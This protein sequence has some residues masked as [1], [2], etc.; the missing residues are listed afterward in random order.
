MA[1]GDLVGDGSVEVVVQTKGGRLYI[2]DCAG[3]AEGKAPWPLYM[4]NNLRNGISDGSGF[5]RGRAKHLP[6]SAQAT[7]LKRA[8]AAGDWSTALTMYRDA[9]QTVQAHADEVGNPKALQLRQAGMLSIARILNTRAQRYDE[10]AE[11]YRTAVE[12]APDTWLACQAIAECN[13]MAQLH[14]SEVASLRPTLAK[15]VAAYLPALDRLQLP[16]SDLCRFAAAQ[17]CLQ[18]ERPEGLAIMRKLGEHATPYLAEMAKTNA[19]YEG[20]PFLLTIWE[21]PRFDLMAGVKTKDILPGVSKGRYVKSLSLG[22]NS[23]AAKDFSI[24]IHCTADVKRA[25]ALGKDWQRG[26]DGRLHRNIE[27][28]LGSSD[29]GSLRMEDISLISHTVT[30]DVLT[31]RREVKRIDSRH[32]RVKLIF[33]SSIPQAE[34]SFYVQGTG[35]KILL[36]SVKP[37]TNQWVFNEQQVSYEVGNYSL[38]KLYSLKTGVPVEAI[39]ELPPGKPCFYPEIMVKLW[40][41]QQKIVVQPTTATTSVSGQIDGIAYQ[42][43]SD[44]RFKV[45]EAIIRPF[46][47][48]TLPKLDVK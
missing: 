32:M 15:A 21:Q 44:Q 7:A 41:R 36:N 25:S 3:S 8:L 40:G 35:A 39:I 37:K 34:F 26:E 43:N 28:Q 20:V 11:A 45:H 6:G 23:S 1:A 33:K 24:K 19:E 14:S 31:V 9:V 10:A 27:K 47:C 4:G 16:E 13:D 30:Q 5:P 38:Q 46:W 2:F 12:M 48:F 18:V 22:V 17:A 42:L 29:L